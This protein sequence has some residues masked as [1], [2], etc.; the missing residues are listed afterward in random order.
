MKAMLI[1]LSSLSA[2]AQAHESVAPHA[3]PH[4]M[5]MLPGI[6]IVACG[7]LS[8]AAALIAYWKIRRTS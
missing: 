6:D 2:S 7:L 1:V 5:S 3:H 4:G 8:L